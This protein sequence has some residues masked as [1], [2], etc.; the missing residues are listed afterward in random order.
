MEVL[1]EF[2]FSKDLAFDECGSSGKYVQARGCQLKLLNEADLEDLAIL[3]ELKITV[4]DDSDNDNITAKVE[5]KVIQD[6]E[7]INAFKL[8]SRFTDLKSEDI[9]EQ[10]KSEIAEAIELRDLEKIV[11]FEETSLEKRQLEPIKPSRI[12]VPAELIK[13]F[14]LDEESPEKIDR[15][16]KT[17]RRNVGLIHA[18]LNPYFKDYEKVEFRSM[19]DNS[20]GFEWTRKLNKQKIQAHFTLV[21]EGEWGAE[22]YELEYLALVR[23]TF[24]RKQKELAIYTIYLS[25]LA[26]FLRRY[27]EIKDFEKLDFIIHLVAYSKK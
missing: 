20:S 19:I 15:M 16:S 4:M 24:L 17:W 3:K 13:G 1:V 2:S 8:L 10:L 6:P 27:N 22:E 26:F 21:A 9:Y 14:L 18:V 25:D 12:Q 11:T 7:A 5:I 23:M